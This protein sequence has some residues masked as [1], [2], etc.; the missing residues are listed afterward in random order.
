MAF[1]FYLDRMCI[2]QATTEIKKSLGGINDEQWS[3]IAMAFT[4]AYGLFEIPTGRLGDRFGSKRV[5]VRV[6]LWF[7]IFTALSGL[8]PG[9]WSLLTV[10]FFFGA[11]EAGALPNAA[12]IIV[13]WF[14]PLERARART[15]MI[16][17]S[18]F[19]GAC[20]FYLSSVI[21]SLLNWRWMFV[22]FGVLGFLWTLWFA[23]TYHD[24]PEEH[25]ETNDA[26]RALLA[27]GGSQVSTH[28]DK[29]PW[30]RV[31]T[32]PSVWLLSSII[33]C[34]AFF[35]Y[36]FFTWYP[37]FIKQAYVV[38]E[39]QS[40]ALSSLANLGGAIGVL[41]G[42]WVANRIQH[43]HGDQVRWQR[44]YC[45]SA[46]LLAAILMYLCTIVPHVALSAILAGL[47]Y[48]CT[49]SHQTIWWGWASQ[50]GGK[51]LG[52]LFG[53]MN[54][55]GVVGAIASQYFFGWLSRM[56]EAEGYTGMDRY[57][58]AFY[59][60][61]SVLVLGAFLWSRVRLLRPID[62]HGTEA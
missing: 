29:I 35:A 58:P 51:H 17:S 43:I 3:F 21:I 30:R 19:G 44:I 36:F 45:V 47:A 34:S 40:G 27:A 5:L 4:L 55:A 8:C 41:V 54:G 46:F 59:V 9:Y 57:R 42:G 48:M 16:A 62:Q 38:T 2:A 12:R 53:L 37:T 23:A 49:L 31:L 10:R 1:I 22:F 7:S 33:M 13:R 28:H 25:P 15:W 60:Y 39:Q 14:P 26:E 18:Y 32:H 56:R 24:N 11:G 20:A 6:V 61:M 50:I 52:S